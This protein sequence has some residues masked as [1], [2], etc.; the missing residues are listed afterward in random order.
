MQQ[1]GTLIVWKN[2]KGYGFIKPLVGPDLFVHI[3]DFGRISRSPQV[4]DRVHFQPMQD[5]QGRF[6]AA[7]VRIEGLTQPTVKQSK[8][9]R[10]HQ[11]QHK[12]SN[13][14]TPLKLIAAIVIALLLLFVYQSVP[15]DTSPANVQLS[16]NDSVILQAYRNQQ[17]NLQLSGSGII[18]KILP[19]DRQ[20]SQH[21]R[22][23]LQLPSG[24]TVLVAHNIDLAPRINGLR[25][26]DRV[27]FN[28]EYEWNQQGGVMHWT[29]HDPAGRHTDGWLEHQGQRYQ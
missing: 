19:D 7:D 4:G 9:P 12:R 6:R 13:I 3:R 16:D 24:I 14:P 27:G 29:H 20:G 26:G 17:S 15:N 28:G 1:T 18:S 8:K 21:Q 10:R 5:N 2:A 25:K 11:N 22:F 23:I